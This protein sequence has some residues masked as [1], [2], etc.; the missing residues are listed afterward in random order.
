MRAVNAE[1]KAPATHGGKREI[2]SLNAVI[3]SLTL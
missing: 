1:N 3:Y 2:G